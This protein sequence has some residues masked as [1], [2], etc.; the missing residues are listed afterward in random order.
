MRTITYGPEP[1]PEGIISMSMKG[2]VLGK[3]V[4]EQFMSLLV[5]DFTWSQQ[6]AMVL[7]ACLNGK[8]VVAIVDT[9]SSGVV[10]SE[11]C[12]CRLKLVHDI[13]IEFTITSATDTN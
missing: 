4:N 6:T 13:E 10:V 5:K 7:R 8:N 3:E 9:G 1:N 2:P 11:S 12:F